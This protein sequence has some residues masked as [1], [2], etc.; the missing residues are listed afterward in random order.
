MRKRSLFILAVG[1]VAILLSIIIYIK[2]SHHEESGVSNLK[3]SVK[4]LR[5][6]ETKS[7]CAI[8]AAL[9]Y[10]KKKRKSCDYY[11]TKE[12]TYF[13][14]S[15]IKI[16]DTNT[17][18]YYSMFYKETQGL[19]VLTRIKMAEELLKFQGDTDICGS[20]IA[21]YNLMTSQLWMYHDS[22]YSMQIEALYLINILCID[23]P[24]NYSPFPV[25][26]NKTSKKILNISGNDI[27]DAY[28]AYRVFLDSLKTSNSEKK[29]SNPLEKTN[30]WWYD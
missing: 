26:Q 13:K 20:K 25:L 10:F 29:D 23:K 12:N 22:S 15:Y 9:K 4:V 19:P 21:C 14:I 7:A 1:V 24:F 27:D 3:D 8:N 28:N 30:V 16:K 11:N 18:C 2:Q 5:K 6:I 17:D